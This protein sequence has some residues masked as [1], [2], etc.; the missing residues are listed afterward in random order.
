MRALDWQNDRLGARVNDLLLVCFLPVRI[1]FDLLLCCCGSESRRVIDRAIDGATD[2]HSGC[3]IS[4]AVE[5]VTLAQFRFVL[6]HY[7]A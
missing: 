7:I 2:A 1:C 3:V 4:G 5:R 6:Y